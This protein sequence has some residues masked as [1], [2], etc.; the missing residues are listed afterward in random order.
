MLTDVFLCVC[1]IRYIC[2]Q[3]YKEVVNVYPSEKVG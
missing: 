2:M 3:I 1:Y